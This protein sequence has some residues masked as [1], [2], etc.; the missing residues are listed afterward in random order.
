MQDRLRIGIRPP[1]A[2]HGRCLA[3][4]AR[5]ARHPRRSRSGA[6]APAETISTKR[7]CD[8]FATR[9]ANSTGSLMPCCWP[10]ALGSRRSR[11]R[12]RCASPTR[13]LQR[14][15]SSATRT[16]WNA[17]LFRC[18]TTASSSRRRTARFPLPPR[19]RPAPATMR[20]STR[21][22]AFGKT[23]PRAGAAAPG[24]GSRSRRAPIEGVGGS[25]KIRNA[26]AG[27][28]EIETVMLVSWLPFARRPNRECRPLGRESQPSSKSRGPEPN[29]CAPIARVSRTRLRDELPGALPNRGP[30][31][32]PP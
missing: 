18:C 6:R 14:R 17:S 13:S 32:I 26:R 16:S 11:R 8:P 24:S 29:R 1:T 22:I 30:R 28:A 10:R 27:G 7:R 4:S 25:I 21:S 12:A 19:S 23:T 31:T 2:V 15:R 9:S 20:C 3:R 5:T